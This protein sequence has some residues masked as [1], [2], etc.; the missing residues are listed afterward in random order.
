MI[1]LN[2]IKKQAKETCDYFYE[3]E[4]VNSHYIPI[5]QRGSTKIICVGDKSTC[6]CPHCYTGIDRLCKIA[7]KYYSQKI[8]DLSVFLNVLEK[9][10]VLDKMLRDNKPIKN[11]VDVVISLGGNK[12]E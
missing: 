12:N 4:Y 9:Y 6:I 7:G 11:I 3:F 2:E 10:P 8:N 5:C 1:T